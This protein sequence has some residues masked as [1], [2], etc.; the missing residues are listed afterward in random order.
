MPKEFS[1]KFGH[2]NCAMLRDSAKLLIF[3]LV[4]N[5]QTAADLRRKHAK[6]RNARSGFDSR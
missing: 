1:D 6:S 4:V 5:A 3:V 2:R